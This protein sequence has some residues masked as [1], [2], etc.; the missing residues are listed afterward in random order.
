MGWAGRLFGIIVFVGWNILTAHTGGTAD[1][2]AIAG[3]QW[4][5]PSYLVSN[6]RDS[7]EYSSSLDRSSIPQHGLP[8]DLTAILPHDGRKAFFPAFWLPFGRLQLLMLGLAE[9]YSGNT[10]L[11]GANADIVLHLLLW[12][13]V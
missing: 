10:A 5:M 3:V 4:Q 11:K 6:I 8:L 12:G 1:L 13:F 7:A 2:P 9:T